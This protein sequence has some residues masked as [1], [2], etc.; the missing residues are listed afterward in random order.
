MP[1]AK[2]FICRKLSRFLGQYECVITFGTALAY[3]KGERHEELTRKLSAVRNIEAQIDETTL[4]NPQ[5]AAG[6]CI[7]CPGDCSTVTAW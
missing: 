6:F 5:L 3:W 7:G 1:P 4:C 2:A